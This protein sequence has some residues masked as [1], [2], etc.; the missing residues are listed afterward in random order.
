MEGQI[1]L[2]YTYMVSFLFA[3]SNTVELLVV[4][5]GWY[6]EIALFA[7]IPWSKI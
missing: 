5:D 3:T 1:S 6:G 2:V 4:S 7:K